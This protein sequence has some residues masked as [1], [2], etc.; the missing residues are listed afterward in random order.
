ME[1][2]AL[3]VDINEIVSRG[4]STPFH[5]SSR[6]NKLHENIFTPPKDSITVSMNRLRYVD[7]HFCKQ[8]AK[9]INYPN[10]SSYFG[11]VTIFVQDFYSINQSHDRDYPNVYASPM[12]NDKEYYD[13]NSE[14]VYINSL[15]NPA[16]CDL[17]YIE[18]NDINQP[19]T[20]FRKIAKQFL[21]VAKVYLDPT[22]SEEM[23][24]GHLPLHT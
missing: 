23:W 9:T 13:T 17:C 21:H 8:H 2:I 22:P 3:E 4:I 10:E 14:K 18:S 12:K 5:F 19:H 1:E 20:A 6:K 16:H 24:R 7:A 11:L 15:G